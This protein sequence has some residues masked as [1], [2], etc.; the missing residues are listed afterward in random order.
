[1]AEARLSAEWDQTASLWLLIANALRDSKAAPFKLDDIHPFRREPPQ[2]PK[3]ISE[4]GGD[5]GV[6]YAKP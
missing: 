2:A 5:L 6:Q 3:P 1:M 4:L